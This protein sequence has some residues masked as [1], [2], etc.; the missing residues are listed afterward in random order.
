[1]TID[2]TNGHPAMDYREHHRTYGGFLRATV[3][4]MVLVTLI[5]LGMLIFLV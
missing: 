1:M 5:L 4:L 3:A 2:T